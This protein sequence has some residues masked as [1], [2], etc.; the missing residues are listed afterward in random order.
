MIGSRKR[1]AAVKA[2][3]L[4]NGADKEVIER[5]YT[6]VGLDIGAKTPEEIAVAIA[7]QIIQVKN[8]TQDSSFSEEI[9]HA[10]LDEANAAEPKV[11]AVIIRRKGS[12][13]RRQMRRHDWRRLCGV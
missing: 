10:V 1:S 11:L 9:L 8:K 13:P 3:L 4:E 12:V 2:A 7:A 5:V 6:P